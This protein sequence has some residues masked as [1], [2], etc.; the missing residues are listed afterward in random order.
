[1]DSLISRLVAAQEREA[2]SPRIK[3]K[4]SQS[5][6][7]SITSLVESEN[8]KVGVERQVSIK[9]AFTVASRSL[10]KTAAL[11]NETRFFSAYREVASFLSLAYNGEHI[12]GK[13]DHADL[14]PIG[15]PLSSRSHFMTNFS[16][17]NAQAR[18]IAADPRV[19]ESVKE[20][21]A[22]AYSQPLLSVERSHAFARIQALT[23]GL[24]PQELRLD[25]SLSALIAAG[26][27]SA[28]RSL[29]ARMQRRDRK[30]R[31]ANEGG[32]L[33]FFLRMLD[34][35][36]H[37]VVGKFAGNSSNSGDYTVE[38]H[39]VPGVP[40]GLYDISTSKT[41]AIKAI[42]PS[43]VTKDHNLNVQLPNGVEAENFSDLKP[44]ASPDGWDLVSDHTGENLGPDKVFKS[45]DN[46]QVEVYNPGNKSAAKG[47]KYA[48]SGQNTY[49]PDPKLQGSK[50]L[51]KN[52][53]GAEVTG[54]PAGPKLNGQ[55]P[56]YIISRINPLTGKPDAA[57]GIAQTWADIQDMADKDQDNFDKAL[58][59]YQAAFDKSAAIT[60]QNEE[61]KANQEKKQAET[62]ESNLKHAEEIQSYH[63]AGK[64]V[65]GND[66]PEGWTA[67]LSKTGLL[68]EKNKTY[69]DLKDN[70]AHI[71]QYQKSLKNEDGISPI[72]HAQWSDNDKQLHVDEYKDKSF[73]DWNDLE[74]SL[75]EIYDVIADK[76]K[77]SAKNVLGNYA[78]YY[79]F[80]MDDVSKFIDSG[81]SASELQTYLE[82]N[83][84]KFAA[85]QDTP[86]DGPMPDFPTKSEKEWDV[87]NTSV[88]KAIGNLL[89]KNPYT[90]SDNEK[91]IATLPETS[92][93]SGTIVSADYGNVKM[94]FKDKSYDS[95]AKETTYS[96]DAEFT[97][98]DGELVDT[99]YGVRVSDDGSKEYFIDD[100]IGDSSKDPNDLFSSEVSNFMDKF[101]DS[102]S[103]K[104]SPTF[105]FSNENGDVKLTFDKVENDKDGTKTYLWDAEVTDPGETKS[106]HLTYGVRF[107]PD[108]TKE[109]LTNDGKHGDSSKD[110]QDLFPVEVSDHMD[111]FVEGNGNGSNPPTPPTSPASPTESP[112]TE[113]KP[114]TDWTVPN[115]AYKLQTKYEYEPQGRV[116][117]DSS[118][119]TDDPKVL[120]NKF[121]QDELAGALT[122]ALIGKKD[123]AAMFKQELDNIGEDDE[124][125]P[126]KKSKPG[127][128]PKPVE[129]KNIASGAGALDFKAGEEYVPAEAIYEALKDK[130]VD[131]DRLVAEI[132]DSALG[133][134]KN[135]SALKGDNKQEQI[136]A[137]SPSVLFDDLS[138]DK[139]I[140]ELHSKLATPSVAIT[141]V[142]MMNDAK[143][144][145]D[146]QNKSLTSV[147][148]SLK[149]INEAGNYEGYKSLLTDHIDK[150]FSD[151]PDDQQAFRAM[152]GLL[153]AL[154]G[155]TADFN[156]G[157]SDFGYAIDMAIR[158]HNGTSSDED[159]VAFVKKWGTFDE[160]IAS[161]LYIAQGKEDI[162]SPDSLA[163][164]YFKLMNYLGTD[165][166]KTLYR[167]IELNVDSESLE[168][169]TT[170]GGFVSIDPRS[171]SDDRIQAEKYSR[172][173]NAD[174]DKASVILQVKPGQATAFD[175][176][177]TSMYEDEREHIVW[178]DYTVT[179][180]KVTEEKNGKTVYGVT[181][182]KLSQRDAVLNSYRSNSDKFLLQ[183]KAVELP[184]GYY[185]PDP[186][187][188]LPE[189]A[190][191]DVVT[192]DPL[193]IA[194]DYAS[195]DLVEV[196]RAGIEDGSGTAQLKFDEEHTSSIPIEA[197]RD[198]LQIQGVDTNEILD[199]I[200]NTEPGAHAV[201]DEN[202][203]VADSL[204]DSPV[205]DLAN[206]IAAEYD[207]APYKKV[208]GQKGSNE[209]GTYEDPEGNQAYIKTPKSELHAQNEVLASALYRA[210]DVPAAEM[211][212]GS[213]EDGALK[214]YSPM[215]PGAEE[216]MQSKL[217]DPEYLK[218]LQDGFAVD[219]WL[220]NWDVAGLAFDN[221]VTDENGDPVRVDPGGALLFRAMGAP[222]GKLFGDKVT[223]LDTLRDAKMNPQSATIFGSMTDEQQKE[224]ARKLLDISNEEIGTLVH[225]V[226]SDPETASNLTTTLE[227]R[228]YDILDRYGLLAEDTSTIVDNAKIE[229]PN[230]ISDTV[231]T[232]TPET[233]DEK[234][235]T[236]SDGVNI[237][238]G[239]QVKHKKT[240]IVGTVTKY[241]KGN[242]SYV[243]V[244]D[245]TGPKPMVKSTKQLLSIPGNG[246]GEKAPKA[247]KAPETPEPEAPKAPTTPEPEVAPAPAPE[248]VNNER[249]TIVDGVSNKATLDNG[250]SY[251]IE[252]A[253]VN[254][255]GAGKSGSV[256]GVRVTLGGNTFK[257]KNLIKEAG[258]K[259]DG[260]KKVWSKAYVELGSFPNLSKKNIKSDLEKI[261][262][263]QEPTAPEAPAPEIPQEAPL[264]PTVPSAS[265]EIGPGHEVTDAKGNTGFIKSIN[266]DNYARVVF[267]DGTEHWRSLK[268]L[269]STGKI[270]NTAALQQK[271]KVSKITGAGVE[272]VTPEKVSDWS[273]SEFGNIPSLQDAITSMATTSDP[274]AGQA[275]VSVAVDSHSL[276]D[277]DVRVMKVKNEDGSDGVRLKFK[278]TNWAANE[279]VSGLLKIAKKSAEERAAVGFDMGTFKVD[280][281]K[282]NDDGSLQVDPAQS[283]FKSNTGRV[284][285]ITTPEGI[286]IRFHRGNT[287]ATSTVTQNKHSGSAYAFH[288]MVTIQ[289]PANVT[290][291]QISHAL[292]VAGV[293]DVRPST[294]ADAKTLIE[295][296]LMSIFDKQNDPKKNLSGQERV[297]SLKRVEDKYGITTADVLLSTGASGRIETNLSEEAALKLWEA[298]GKPAGLH[299]GLTFPKWVHYP[300]AND[301]RTTDE[302]KIDF[303]V[304]L[305]STPQEGLLSTTVRWTE[306]IGGNGMSSPQDI[307]TGG[308][309]YVFTT[310]KMALDSKE[311][312]VYD[313][314][315]AIYFDP[316]KVYRRLDFFA[317]VTDKFGARVMG[318]D[319]IKSS[320][321]GVASEIMFKQRLGW[322][323]LDSVILSPTT[324]SIVLGKL[325]DMGISEIGGRAIEDVIIVATKYK[326]KGSGT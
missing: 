81:A 320:R 240:G 318:E 245:G 149:A 209:G 61:A 229:E 21:V 56:T 278:L 23:A 282:K 273:T 35:A 134:N 36:I 314:Q 141:S 67:S 132:Y 195:K 25:A 124:E 271:V 241:D 1:V 222:K 173:W 279:R 312:G 292:A 235:Y 122:E 310:P 82:T 101:V 286:V 232:P 138:V 186:D 317:N 242:Q 4:S 86:W 277:L 24:I 223:E 252:E 210:L 97:D 157:D 10:N 8:A 234:V 106:N 295:N 281:I 206:E 159:V 62:K 204:S 169:Y 20:L 91:K 95:S 168:S 239:M 270:D 53:D 103:G 321:P 187:K 34:G 256:D 290:P 325:H 269:T 237:T 285:T 170:Q 276:E 225:S 42:L 125:A 214:V 75:P 215:V 301:T 324:R 228:R 291:E 156:D 323:D 307:A 163:G 181:L 96:W 196:F 6:R 150:A 78:D 188:Y 137:Q 51:T 208:G 64:D 300:A 60:K 309:D 90:K 221:V 58:P 7:A 189:N 220:A 297:D 322:A 184:E 30:G 166:Q 165:N 258:F 83:Y 304:A 326:N 111:K 213:G 18:W 104:S 176:T 54:A 116:D 263:M 19:D 73:K 262:N 243:Y 200:A 117:E 148:D 205:T 37:S 183:N 201:A 92:P 22:S 272:P 175:A 319:T 11:S 146:E 238:V 174:N 112:S 102:D 255:S 15:H 162:N 80:N 110:P 253:T 98:T 178:G 190:E 49:L 128:K 296:R 299:H 144:S 302:R 171:F 74:N 202:P 145:G 94:T 39:G 244:D 84:P 231:S 260:E 114:F 129:I 251:S 152:W 191:G 218:K 57:V 249:K 2:I 193:S 123:F 294:P 109:Y 224:S 180:V 283:G 135:A 289:A 268:T 17:R 160:L 63:D 71:Q 121:T 198:A 88:G 246:G 68:V 40:D 266:K 31:F 167:G 107:N 280:Y 27:D 267:Q 72:I 47:L 259:W 194:R 248:I 179:K 197:I 217:K 306:G 136:N 120:A 311:Y 182:E 172:S 59:E 265:A 48:F 298:V 164:S 76:N 177:N 26:N 274:R 12:N 85:D 131:A 55:S 212:M 3:P 264:T 77:Q 147:G 151:N 284:Y 316:K 105:N 293:Q 41:E 99:V 192:D 315:M 44:K 227:A 275:G 233:A 153:T 52:V 288:N 93:A 9:S 118:D 140:L 199:D 230:T 257:N 130:G 5:L 247:P 89:S 32:G 46:Y 139:G 38:L 287:N 219:A 115:N 143:D 313:S 303:Y 113:S 158:K 216:N 155:G 142:A 100:K 211:Y 45:D 185:V 308:A 16:L 70:K 250:V 133:E 14:L 126:A 108:G 33:Q 254:V 43:G 161:K 154:D 28:S 236:T 226:I 305:L 127:P 69:V 87:R 261:G 79:G 65:Y 207:L 50:P 29:R 119:F 203:P 13:N 66:I